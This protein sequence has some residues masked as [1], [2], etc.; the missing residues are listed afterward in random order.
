MHLPAAAKAESR[1]VV[2]NTNIL[3]IPASAKGLSFL[4]FVFVGQPP[5]SS[6]FPF[7]LCCSF[8]VSL[9]VELT[10]VC[11]FLAIST[12]FFSFSPHTT[13]LNWIDFFGRISRAYQSVQSRVIKHQSGGIHSCASFIMHSSIFV[14]AAALASVMAMVCTSLH[15][16]PFRSN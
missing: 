1:R 10:F 2:G 12:A 3:C 7:T 6:I 14:L 8:L 13:P 15:L 4:P 5:A 9:S 16:I 11:I